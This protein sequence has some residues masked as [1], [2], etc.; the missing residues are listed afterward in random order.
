LYPG[1]NEANDPHEPA[2]FD[3][4]TGEVRSE[5]YDTPTPDESICDCGLVAAGYRESW[6]VWHTAG[7]AYKRALAWLP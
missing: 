2:K 3:E 6:Q 5:R 1:I 4:H 7:C